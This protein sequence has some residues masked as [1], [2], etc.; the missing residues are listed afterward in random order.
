MG[1]TTRKLRAGACI[2][3]M[4][5]AAL[6]WA[7][8][9][10]FDPEIATFHCTDNTDCA[11]V[12]GYY[13]AGVCKKG[14]APP[15]GEGEG[16]GEENIAFDDGHYIVVATINEPMAT[17]INLI[18]HIKTLDDG[19]V[20]LAAAAGKAIEGAPTNTA[21][22][23]ELNVQTD[24]GGYAVFAYGTIKYFEQP[25]KTLGRFFESDP[26]EVNIKLGPIPFL[27]GLHEMRLSGDV[28]KD[29]ETDKD[30]ISGT[31][32]YSSVTLTV[33]END[34]EYGAG[35]PTFVATYVPPE[36]VPQGA[37]DL[38]GDLCGVVPQQCEPPEGFPGEEFCAE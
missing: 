13:C 30:R 12:D 15:S 1:T 23:D 25:D 35:N 24:S 16:D 21:N 20:A 36:K 28:E 26:F 5:L 29:S 6:F 32:S 10:D 3:L 8:T 7:C 37:P 9:E 14:A 34:T 33:G 19:T 2:V 17:V 18:T 38:C 4:S 11:A 27:V 22:P 31:L